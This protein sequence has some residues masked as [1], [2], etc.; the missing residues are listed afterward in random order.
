MGPLE[1]V[2]RSGFLTFRTTNLIY[3]FWTSR[4]ALRLPKIAGRANLAEE[5]WSLS[6]TILVIIIIILV[7]LYLNS[8]S[9]LSL[10]VGTI[11]TLRKHVLGHFLS[12]PLC[13]PF[14]DPVKCSRNVWMVPKSHF[15]LWCFIVSSKDWRQ[16]KMTREQKSPQS[17][18]F[19][20]LGGICC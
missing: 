16:Q 2:H 5:P 3:R 18:I 12:H 14:S 20:L 15:P 6:I 10:C 13:E 19:D 7:A 8:F 9:V 11:H 1:R 4:Q 17:V